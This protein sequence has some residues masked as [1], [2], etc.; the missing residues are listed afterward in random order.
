MLAAGV[1][2]VTAY[3]AL[4]DDDGKGKGEILARMFSPTGGN[5][6]VKEMYKA[7]KAHAETIAKEAANRAAVKAVAAV[8][9]DGDKAVF[10]KT[11]RGSF[12]TLSPLAAAAELYALIKAHEKS[13]EVEAHLKSLMTQGVSVAANAAKAA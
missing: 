10:S 3:D 7:A 12:N 2:E 5:M 11:A 4:A 13:S 6:L 8:A 9:T 1:A